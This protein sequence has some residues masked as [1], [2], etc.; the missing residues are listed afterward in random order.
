MLLRTIRD[1]LIT[2]NLLYTGDRPEYHNNINVI[3]IV[4]ALTELPEILKGH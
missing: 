2:N 4:T 3:P 1:A